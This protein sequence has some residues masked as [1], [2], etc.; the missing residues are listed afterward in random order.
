MDH[1]L[2]GK[3]T[4]VE[5]KELKEGA[6]KIFQDAKFTLHKWHAN[7]RG[8]ESDQPSVEM[9]NTF[10][11]QL[12]HPQAVPESSLSDDKVMVSFDVI[13]LFTAIP[14]QKACDYN[15]K[16]KLEQDSIL[17]CRT[18]SKLMK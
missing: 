6:I 11:L 17:S 1:L 4:V 10:A 9:K 3:P 12:L 16:E 2:S 7:D 18:H 15:I 8:L 14:V 5:A 13:S